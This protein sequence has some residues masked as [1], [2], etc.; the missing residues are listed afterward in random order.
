M[1][2]GLILIYL[3]DNDIFKVKD[4]AKLNNVILSF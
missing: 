2:L 4:N 1:K 3:V